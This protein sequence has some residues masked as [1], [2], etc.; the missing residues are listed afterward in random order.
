VHLENRQSIT[1]RDRNK[2]QNVLTNP[3][4]GKTTLTE[5]LSNNCKDSDGRHLRYI[6]YLSEYR[7]DAQGKVWIRRLSKREPSIGRLVY[8]HPSSGELFYL[9]MLVNHKAG[10]TS[11][12]NIRTFRNQVCDTYRSACEKLG[13]LGDDK[14][15]TEAFTEASAW[16]NARELRLLFTHMLLYCEITNPLHLWTE[17]WHHMSDDIVC[18]I[19]KVANTHSNCIP[20][21]DIQQHVL[22]EIEKLLNSNSPS[23]TLSD[24]GLPKPSG[25][26]LDMLQNRLM[27]EERCYDRESLK[28]EHERLLRGL[29]SKQL[30]AYNLVT[31]SITENKQI[32]L[33]VYGH[34]GTGKT[35][36]WTTIISALRSNGKIVLAVA[37]S[38]IA[39]LLLPSGRTA[40]SRFK[41]PIDITDE[42]ICNVKKTTQLAKL[43]IE[44]SLIVWDEA[45]MNDRRCF[46]SLGRSLR[47]I[48][49]TND[50][51]FGG[52]SILLG[53]DFRQTLPVKIKAS[54]EQIIAA[55]L[56]KSYLWSAFKIIKLTENMR[57][58]RPNLTTADRTAINNFFTWLVNIG[59]GSIGTTQETSSED[60]KTIDIPIEHLIEDTEQPLLK[61][62]QF[63]YD[64][65]TL[66]SPCAKNL[67]DKAIVCP[68]NETVDEINKLVLQRAPGDT[69]QYLSTDS[70]TPRA[71]DKGD[72]ELMYPIEHLNTLSF[73]GVP[74][75][76]L[77]LKINTPVILLRNLNQTCG[78]C[79]GTRLLVTQLL[80]RI[81]EA[82]IITGTSIGNKVY[83][84]RIPF[85][86]DNKELPFIFKR[87]QFP[88]KVCYA[89]TIN[90]SQGQSL[91]KIG[92]YLPQPVFCHGQLYVALSR[93]TSPESLKIVIEAQEGCK[94]N[95]TKNIVFADFL[96][97]IEEDINQ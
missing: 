43:L 50:K 60:T 45:P 32:L 46:E 97:I 36:L 22:Y 58:Q 73:N 67:A 57:L 3:C 54:K 66:Q 94:P 71:G 76:C 75:H 23:S 62:T 26:L 5:W 10:C 61:L 34:G 15:W 47:D 93:A 18:H 48:L 2:L 39:S 52:K 35:Y 27:M 51:P 38:E 92:V 30:D 53:G 4:V 56:P 8:V 96:R 84:P 90:K 82:K 63:I 41:I 42:S 55:S 88:I 77:E 72:T 29:N 85:V 24:Y 70:I 37:A 95:T 17:Q 78:L 81:I 25:D 74:P 1:F 89:M 86:H 87:R 13:L 21:T 69:S 7:W 28:L 11:Y 16:A 68:K 44:T 12:S 65:L 40:H 31:N 83:I 80:P 49:N 64:T 6:D 9:C 19:R 20:Q 59:D 14:E 79:N 33:F 91:N